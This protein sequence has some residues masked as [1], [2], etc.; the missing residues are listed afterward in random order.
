MILAKIKNELNAVIEKTVYFIQ[1]V[2]IQTKI[3]RIAYS[4]KRIIK[5]CISVALVLTGRKFFRRFKSRRYGDFLTNVSNL[6][7]PITCIVY[8]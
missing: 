3:T 5:N 1:E 7:P 2:C 4:I 6:C 8:V